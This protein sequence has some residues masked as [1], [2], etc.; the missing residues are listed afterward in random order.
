MILHDFHDFLPKKPWFWWK[1]CL[2]H[3][4]IIF[5]KYYIWI[6]YQQIWCFWST[7]SGFSVFEEVF[8]DFWDR[9]ILQ[10]PQMVSDWLRVEHTAGRP[11]HYFE[12]PKF[13]PLRSFFCFTAFASGSRDSRFGFLVRIQGCYGMHEGFIFKIFLHHFLIKNPI[14][15]TFLFWDIQITILNSDFWPENDEIF[16]WK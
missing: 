3:H 2:K 10:M 7:L 5:Q 13:C 6:E 15:D 9:R 12:V 14:W 11:S 16:F 8:H 1:K 4:E